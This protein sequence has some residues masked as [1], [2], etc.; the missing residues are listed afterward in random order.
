MISLSS[1]KRQMFL[2]TP[3]SRV[4]TSASACAGVVFS[5]FYPR[6]PRGWRRHPA[7]AV[8]AECNVSI[9][10]TL[11]GGDVAKAS[12][13]TGL[14]AQVSIHATLAGGDRITKMVDAAINVSI[15]ATLA[16]GDLKAYTQP[17]GNAGFLSTPPSRVAT[18]KRTTAPLS[19]RVSIHATLAGG[20]K[21]DVIRNPDNSVVSIHATLAGG[22]VRRVLCGVR[23][24]MFL[25]TPPSRVATS[26]VLRGINP[27]KR[28]YPRHPRG[29]RPTSV[30][31]IQ[32]SR[33]VS[34][35]ATLA[36]GDC[37]SYF[38]FYTNFVF[39]STPPSRVATKIY[40]LLCLAGRVS[41]HA[42]LAGG[43]CF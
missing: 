22:D 15:H 26:G 3:P 38:Q 19:E 43:D 10:A 11:A 23:L 35:H 30:C 12:Q 36:G 16:G 34:I 17:P 14:N 18:G 33:L 5:S 9:H 2:S 13:D 27:S 29:W 1:S 40:Q 37:N 25:S 20:D 41:I 42:T 4:A 31:I 28:F 8:H 7:R 21:I 24:P 6:H 32:Q 39:L